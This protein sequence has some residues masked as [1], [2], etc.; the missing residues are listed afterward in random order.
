MKTNLRLVFAT[1]SLG[2]LLAVTACTSVG[3]GPANPP[4]SG[5]QAIMGKEPE[6]APIPQKNVPAGDSSL[7]HKK[8]DERI[9]QPKS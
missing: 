7:S 2:S 3:E 1:L 8:A 4:S 6:P 5:N 9:D